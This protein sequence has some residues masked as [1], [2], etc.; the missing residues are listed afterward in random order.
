MSLTDVTMVQR[1]PTYIMSTKEGMPRML[2]GIYSFDLRSLADRFPT[3]KHLT[4]KV[5]PQLT[6]L[7]A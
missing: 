4:G 6:S 5:V 7:I 1:G 3:F 2:G